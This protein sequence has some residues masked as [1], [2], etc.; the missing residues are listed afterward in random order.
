M[1][2]LQLNT[3]NVI[4]KKKKKQLP[5]TWAEVLKNKE[6]AKHN[7]INYLNIYNKVQCKI[8]LHKSNLCSNSLEAE[9]DNWF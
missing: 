6:E 4:L 9:G 7:I 1:N 2:T 8:K 5:E 3:K